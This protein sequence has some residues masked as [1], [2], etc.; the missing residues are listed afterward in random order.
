M[1]KALELFNSPCAPVSPLT[2]DEE[3]T[4]TSTSSPATV[5]PDSSNNQKSDG[6]PSAKRSLMQNSDEPCSISSSSPIS[7]V[8]SPVST[9]VQ[10]HAVLP[11]FTNAKT[12]Y[13]VF[14]HIP[15]PI[16]CPQICGTP[17]TPPKPQGMDVYGSP[18]N[19]THISAGL[20]YHPHVTSVAMETHRLPF[21]SPIG[22]KGFYIV[23]SN[24]PCSSSDN[25]LG[26]INNF[27]LHFPPPM[28]TKDSE[29]KS[30][31]H[32]KDE[33]NKSPTKSPRK[34]QESPSKTPTKSPKVKKGNVPVGEGMEGVP[35]FRPTAQEF[36]NPLKYVELIKQQCEQYGI[37][38]IEPPESWMVRTVVIK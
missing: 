26:M 28:L 9:R 2:D 18:Y 24:S 35:V 37:C 31:K 10:P 22:K 36:K 8:S 29:S 38:V 21:C 17:L 3:T 13:G 6:E 34:S 1:Q 27:P 14:T 25:T 11:Q 16:P 5:K 15:T 4:K 32:L 12:N 20:P 7:T 33:K 30:V 23:N 19:N